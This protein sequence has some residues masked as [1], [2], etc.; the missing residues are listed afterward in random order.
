MLIEAIIS[1]QIFPGFY[2]TEYDPDN[3]DED[4]ER[5]H[6]PDYE[7]YKNRVCQG[8][9]DIVSKHI[10]FEIKSWELNSPKAYNYRNDELRIVIDTTPEEILYKLTKCEYASFASLD[11]YVNFDDYRDNQYHIAILEHIIEMELSEFD[12]FQEISEQLWI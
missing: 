6:E 11:D 8:I 12:I 5:I 9:I 7:D 3:F 1:E 10:P 4:E 2:N